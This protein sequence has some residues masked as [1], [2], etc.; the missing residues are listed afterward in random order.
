M[1]DKAL[2]FD[3]MKDSKAKISE[4]DRIIVVE[5]KSIKTFSFSYIAKKLRIT[6]TIKFTETIK[7]VTFY[8]NYNLISIVYKKGTI[9][10]LNLEVI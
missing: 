8:K 6:K 2:G 7:D 1:N 4:E 3:I 5:E 10:T 9:Q